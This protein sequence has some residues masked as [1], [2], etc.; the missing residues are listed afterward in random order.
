[1]RQG[2]EEEAA[3]DHGWELLRAIDDQDGS[4]IFAF[5][6]RVRDASDWDLKPNLDNALGPEDAQRGRAILTVMIKGDQTVQNSGPPRDIRLLRRCLRK[7]PGSVT[8]SFLSVP[9]TR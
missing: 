3:H 8:G 5:I 6:L 4:V 9:P 1:M 7:Y 2:L